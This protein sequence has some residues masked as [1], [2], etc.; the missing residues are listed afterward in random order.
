MKPVRVS[1]DTACRREEVY[2]FLDV[3]ANHRSFNDH[4][5]VDLEYSGADRGVGSR[6]RE[7]TRGALG[8]DVIDIEVVSAEAPVRIVEENIGA[9]PG[10]RPAQARA[11]ATGGPQPGIGWNDSSLVATAVALCGRRRTPRTA[12]RSRRAPARFAVRLS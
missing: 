12:R 11:R 7:R 8:S 5:L 1:I 9:R 10:P 3:M 2:D 6:A 4:F